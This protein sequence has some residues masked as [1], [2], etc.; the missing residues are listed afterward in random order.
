MA[1]F[2]GN[3]VESSFSDFL[4]VSNIN[5]RNKNSQ[6]FFYYYIDFFI[7]KINFLLESCQRN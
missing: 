6:S 3:W 2:R 5:Y 1:V 4:P 7:L